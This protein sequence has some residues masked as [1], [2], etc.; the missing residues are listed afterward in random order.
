M[1]D[2]A[3]AW[4]VGSGRQEVLLRSSGCQLY[5]TT[6]GKGRNEM[7]QRPASGFTGRPVNHDAAF[8]EVRESVSS[9]VYE[10]RLNLVTV[11]KSHFKAHL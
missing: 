9:K 8:S 6:A 5:L 1:E 3:L 7:L 10:R 11:S 4:E 2:E